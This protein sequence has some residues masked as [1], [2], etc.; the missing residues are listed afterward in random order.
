[1]HSR[2]FSRLA[3]LCA[4]AAAPTL[5]QGQE[6]EVT[7]PDE[8]TARAATEPGRVPSTARYIVSRPRESTNLLPE[9]WAEFELRFYLRDDIVPDG[10]PRDQFGVPYVEGRLAQQNEHGF[11]VRE[12]TIPSAFNETP[13]W[14]PAENVLVVIRL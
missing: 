5:L 8:E 10:F 12:I 13:M 2:P 3:A 11:V 1:M 9:P 14:I 4:L 7:A 6:R